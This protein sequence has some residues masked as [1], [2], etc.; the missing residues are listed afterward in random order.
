MILRNDDY[1]RIER[2]LADKDDVKLEFTIADEVFP[3]GTT[4]Y[5]VVAENTGSDK[6]DEIVML[7]GH[8]D[9]WHSATG[10]TDNGIGSRSC[11]KTR[12]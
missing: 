5:D 6:A 2:L 8:L 10:A 9:S 3:Q 1:G 7:G 12:A 4:S 11:S